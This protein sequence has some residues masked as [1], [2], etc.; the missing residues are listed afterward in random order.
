M[1]SIEEIIEKESGGES[2]FW[3]T[4]DPATY[5]GGGSYVSK[6]RTRELIASRQAFL[7]TDVGD[8]EPGFQGKGRKR[9][10]T[11][12]TPGDTDEKK[13]FTVQDENGDAV[14]PGRATML[15]DFAEHLADGGEPIPVRFAEAGNAVTLEPAHPDDVKEYDGGGGLD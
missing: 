12:S 15:A 5:R 7:V 13:S 8:E 3:A 10:V 6:E 4:R 14:F 11:L 9:V 2:D 1:T